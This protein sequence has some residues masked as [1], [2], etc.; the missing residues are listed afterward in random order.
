M[1]AM[2]SGR[3]LE[4]ILLYCY[5]IFGPGILLLIAVKISE[6]ARK[7]DPNYFPMDPAEEGKVS[8]FIWKAM[9]VAFLLIVGIPVAPML[10]RMWLN[11][12]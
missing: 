6:R 8:G 11:T 3:M 12:P 1:I 9:G 7:K 4:P 5:L 10:I 2:I